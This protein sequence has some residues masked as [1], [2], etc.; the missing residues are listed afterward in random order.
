MSPKSWRDDNLLFED[1]L[2]GFSVLLKQL[3][4]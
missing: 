4:E 3:F 1:I 2:P